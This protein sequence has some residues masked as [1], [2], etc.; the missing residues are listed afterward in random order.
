MEEHRLTRRLTS[1]WNLIKK[2]RGFPDIIQLNT[3]AIED[4]WPYCF[5]VGVDPS[6]GTA[7]KYEYM[8][9]PIAKLYGDDLTGRTIEKNAR[10]FPGAVIHNKLPEVAQSQKPMNDEGHFVSVT[11]KLIKYRACIL[12]FGTEAEG[13]T[14][15]VVGLSCRVFN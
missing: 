3:A 1:Y 2:D 8:G 7:F 10:D 9:E 5:Q 11:G 12:P 13:I 14:H 4:V 6:T 15:I